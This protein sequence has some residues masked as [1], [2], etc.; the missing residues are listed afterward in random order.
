VEAVID[1]MKQI[2]PRDDH[3]RDEIRRLMDYFERNKERMRYAPFRSQG[4]F[5]GS[6]VM[7]AV[8]KTIAG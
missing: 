8:C 1:S 2:E 4:L 5:I 6:G 3:G 7:K